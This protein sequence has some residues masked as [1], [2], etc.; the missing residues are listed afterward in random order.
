MEIV[1]RRYAGLDVH[2]K[3]VVAAIIITNEGKEAYRETRSF[4]TMT[5]E[6]L[7]LSDWLKGWEVTHVTM[8][9]TGENNQFPLK[10]ITPFSACGEK[11]DDPHHPN[12]HDEKGCPFL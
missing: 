6:L 8:E 10:T 2:K 5:S 12:Y 4:G 9:S 7:S 11:G 3:L 1:H